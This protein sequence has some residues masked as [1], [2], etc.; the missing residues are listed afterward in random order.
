MRKL[1]WLWRGIEKV[2]GLAAIPAYWKHSCGAEF[3]LIR[4]HLRPTDDIG[5]TY[6][7]HHPRDHDCPRGIVQ[8]GDGTFAAVCRHPHKLCDDLPLSP[9]EALVFTLDIGALV[10][11]MADALCV[12]IQ[13]LQ[14]QTPGVWA[15]GLSTSRH[16]RNQ[17]VYL[18]VLA[19]HADFRAAL[20]ALAHS[21]PT[22]FVAIAPT[23]NHLTVELH[24][25]LARRQSE[26]ISMDERVGL[27]D[28]GRFVAL[29][30]TD[31]DEIT[32]TLV[33]Q[34]HS[35][36]EKYKRAFNYTVENI[37]EDAAV[38]R[39]DFYKWMKGGLDDASIKSK[40]IQEALH[41][42]PTLSIRR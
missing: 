10:L 32:P 17:P 6:P 31:A 28:D 12:R 42:N 16:T 35:V 4:P 3:P 24:E 27:S 39:S 40:R 30:M 18:L 41:T 15:L 7:C 37:C 13:K 11:P 22:P 9:L 38:N 33:E 36:V 34:R 8:Y 19:R 23:S 14:V 21:C 1:T 25:I 20:S 2:S 29:E 26:F 5:A